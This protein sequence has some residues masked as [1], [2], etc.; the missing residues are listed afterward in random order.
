MKCL[1]VVADFYSDIAEM[2]LEGAV[3]ACALRQVEYDVVRVAGALEIPPT[4]A[5]IAEQVAY[6]GYIALGC[7]IRGETSHYDS[8]CAESA[9]G[10]MDLGTSWLLPI[11][12]GILT[13][14]NRAQALVRADIGQKNK[15]GGAALA[16]IDMIEAVQRV[17][18]S[19]HMQD[20]V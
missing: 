9:R 10:L 4:I 8:V 3:A 18:A 7:V 11:G 5:M 14:E 19:A 13:V 17:V 15:G 1:I 12:N 6:D 16:A 20:D 2:L